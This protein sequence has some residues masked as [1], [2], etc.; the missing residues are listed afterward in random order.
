MY[1]A[2]IVDPVTES[3]LAIQRLME[4]T[5]Q[6]NPILTVFDLTEARKGITTAPIDF[7]F[8]S[9][10]FPEEETAL[11]IENMK[12]TPAGKNCTYILTMSPE[13]QSRTAVSNAMLVGI[14]GFLCQPYTLSSMED[15]TKLA[16]K[17]SCKN[18]EH[19]LYAAT[20]LM[21]TTVDEFS[22]QEQGKEGKNVK[23]LW[24][25]IKESCETYKRVTGSSVRDL[26][27]DSLQEEPPK[28]EE[29]EVGY[30]G[31]S[32]RVRKMFNSRLQMKFKL[33]EKL[34]RD[35][36]GIKSGKNTK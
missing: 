5:A 28:E 3:R 13:S 11:F 25:Q 16:Q 32:E 14:H 12:K 21:L 36:T 31:P 1:R 6:F 26:V 8:I 22:E 34:N 27:E 23:D 30:D 19:R 20:G 2:T 17:V 7:M 15:I 35:L 4:Y 18:T 33:K 9:D 10:S 24:E 29:E